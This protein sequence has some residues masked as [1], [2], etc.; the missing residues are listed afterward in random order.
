MTCH[1]CRQKTLGKHTSCSCCNSLQA[2][3]T[4]LTTSKPEKIAIGS[5]YTCML[6]NEQRM[7]V[8][9]VL[10]GDCLFMRYGEN[11]LEVDELYEWTCPVCRGL[12][13][14]SNHRIRR[15]WLP[16]GTL[17]RRAIAEG[18]C[19][20]FFCVCYLEI[21]VLDERLCIQVCLLVHWTIRSRS[22]VVPHDCIR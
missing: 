18:E 17:Y 21:S 4:S 20:S 11:I 14:C 1:Q 3:I 10:C 22:N 7:P 6:Y 8:Q 2:C 16:T 9:G 19:N 15:G 12:C 13:N 5:C